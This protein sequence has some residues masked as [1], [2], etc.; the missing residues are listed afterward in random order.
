MRSL[1][2]LALTA[3]TCRRTTNHI[4]PW[5]HSLFKSTRLYKHHFNLV[6]HS[7]NLYEIYGYILW[8]H[9]AMKDNVVPS[10]HNQL[11]PCQNLCVHAFQCNWNSRPHSLA[12]LGIDI[13]KVTVQVKLYPLD[14]YDSSF[15]FPSVLE[16]TLA[17]SGSR[18]RLENLTH[19][20]V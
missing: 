4:T 15:A 20:E 13:T 19:I 2:I 3:L 11:Q 7:Y 5:M 10:C 9:G 12:N 16:T 17:I 1:P 18:H 6:Q 8:Y 14:S